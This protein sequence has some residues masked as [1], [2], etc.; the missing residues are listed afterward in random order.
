MAHAEYFWLADLEC[1][2]GVIAF[3]PKS[4]WVDFVPEVTEAERVWEG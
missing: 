4:G 1:P 3:D 2:G